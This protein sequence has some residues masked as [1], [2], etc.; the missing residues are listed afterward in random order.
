MLTNTDNK[1]IN[2][3]LRELKSEKV[4]LDNYSR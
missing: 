2:I 3:K 1:Y 4:F